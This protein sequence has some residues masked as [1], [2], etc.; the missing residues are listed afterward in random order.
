MR[1]CAEVGSE[2]EDEKTPVL[3]SI[4]EILIMSV[5]EGG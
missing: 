1:E 3:V 2:R 5:V 4:P